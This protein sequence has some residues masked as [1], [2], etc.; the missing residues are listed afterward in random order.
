MQGF[1]QLKPPAPRCA[2]APPGPPPAAPGSPHRG[3]ASSTGPRALTTSG[4][5][6][7][8]RGGQHKMRINPAISGRG[9]PFR[10]GGEGRGV[11]AAGGSLTVIVSERQLERVFQQG[12]E[13][14]VGGRQERGRQRERP[15][16]GGLC[17]GAAAEAPSPSAGGAAAGRERGGGEPGR[18][19]QSRAWPGLG[20]PAGR[21]SRGAG[22]APPPRSALPAAL[23]PPARRPLCAARPGRAPMC[24]R[25][26]R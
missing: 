2:S 13:H 3:S 7:H 11:G 6:P 8:R 17:L 1:K 24:R 14:P 15:R 9:P 12:L 20:A 16:H 26:R 18:A 4:P 10:G 25:C 19:G 23:L 22:E 5:L 21:R